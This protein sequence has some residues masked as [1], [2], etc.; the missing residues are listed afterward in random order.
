MST[1]KGPQKGG[2]VRMQAYAKCKKCMGFTSELCLR[3]VLSIE[4]LGTPEGSRS[5]PRL[6]EYPILG[7]LEGST[8]NPRALG[9]F[10]KFSSG[11]HSDPKRAMYF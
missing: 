3:V 6:P 2:I 11:Y 5:N 7:Q 1:V 8:R 9:L 10:Q 4:S